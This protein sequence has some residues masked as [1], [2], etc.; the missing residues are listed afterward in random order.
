MSAAKTTKA[1]LEATLSK[2]QLAAADLTALLRARNPTIWISTREE[3]RVEKF[4]VEAAA[5]AA[6]KVLFWDCASGISDIAGR[7]PTVTNASGNAR[8]LEINGKPGKDIKD[9]GEALDAVRW[10]SERTG[11]DAERIVWVFRDLPIWIEGTIGATPMRALRNLSKYLP[12]VPRPQAQA[13][14]VL[15]TV[16]KVPNDIAGH[17]TVLDWPLPDRSEITKVIDA[18]LNSLPEFEKKEDGTPDETK[19]IR[20]LAFTK[21][22]RELAIDAAVGLTEEEAGACY[23]KS[24][25]QSRTVD[26]KL[27]M[28]EKKRVIS[29]EKVLEWH[30]PIKGGLDAVGGLD[31]LKAWLKVRETTYSPAAREY[32]LPAPKGAVLVGISGC[33]KSLTAKAVATAWQCPLLR[34]DLGALKAKFVGDSEENI[35][36]AFKVIETIDRC[37]VWIDEIEKAMA[38]A[39]SGASDGGV[40]A[41]A[42][43]VVLNWMQER[44]SNAFVIATANSVENLPPE[45]LRKGR[46]DEIF[47]VGLPN[48][49]ERKGVLKASLKSN[50]RGDLKI[51][52]QRVVEATEGFTG[53]E[54]AELVPTSLYVAFA[55][56]ARE[57]S[58]QDLVNAAA[59]VNPLSKT[60]AEAV[61]ELVKWGN[62]N[63]RSATLNIEP[64]QLRANSGSRE[65]DL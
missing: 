3:N 27:V 15:S 59:N 48:E 18:A 10:Y 47:F 38:G 17:A 30:D 26:P 28:G 2:G 8:P 20:S 29:R 40:S 1:A 35:R 37:V 6:Y 44:T 43:G 64:A 46:F 50:G 62:E 9:S 13:I 63:A 25:V 57:P 7:Q 52:Y 51:D 11:K 42:L 34:L 33:G 53:A 45:L 55:D 54:I 41:D 24:L 60:K 31:N 58:T 21:E 56:G 61:A 5:A 32:G 39:S 23:A 16:T 12:G 36:K 4:I 65:L 14:I 49:T 19:P 22:S